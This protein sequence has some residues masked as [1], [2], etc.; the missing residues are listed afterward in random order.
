MIRRAHLA[1]RWYP[2]ESAQCQ[3]KV[4]EHLRWGE[5]VKGDWR[6]LIAPHAGWSYS[7]NAMGLGYQTLRLAQPE[8]DLVVIF[9]SHLGPQGP[10]TVFRGAG[11]ATPLGDIE[12]RLDLVE[13]V[14]AEA[15]LSDEPV[16]PANFDNAV[17][18]HLPFIR[19]CFPNATLLMVGVEASLR[20][21]SIGETVGRVVR[22]RGLDAVFIG[23]T[24]LTH[25]GAGYG[26]TAQGLGEEAVEW[27]RTCNDPGFITS[28]IER[29][30]NGAVEN[31]LNH[32]SACCPG[33]AVAALAARETFHGALIGESPR[34]LTHYLSCDVRPAAD[35]VGYGTLTY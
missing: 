23:S 25:Y 12:T 28:L 27:V 19:H 1:G 7:G 30:Y 9:G 32:Q 17:E 21:V 26:F 34:L 14:G 35:F 11:W 31:A 4:E 10:S 22:E 6:A 20:G 3:D 8:P 33:A 5:P 2:E 18:V 13:V 16:E 29:D 15:G 24:D